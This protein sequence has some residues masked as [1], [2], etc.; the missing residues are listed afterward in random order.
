MFRLAYNTNGLAH[1]R[2]LDALRLLADL[3]YEGVA[4]TP[5]VGGLDLALLDGRAGR[6]RAA[7][8][9]G[10]R[11]RARDR[12]RGALSC[13]TPRRKH[14]PT[15][16]EDEP[17]AR[18]RRVDYL[19]RAVDLAAEVGAPL[20]SLWAGAAPGASGRPARAPA[21]SRASVDRARLEVLWERLAGGLLPVLERGR[22]RQACRSPSSPSRACSSSARPATSSSSG[23]SARPGTSSA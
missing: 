16:L 3:G 23:A 10:A 8:V 13:W 11:P 9:R 17:E 6:G 12:D 18:A 19:L 20:V 1:H 5:D 14:Y 15:L 4:L 22:E 2:V 21:G 7:L